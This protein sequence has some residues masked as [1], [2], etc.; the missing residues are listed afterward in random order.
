MIFICP[1]IEEEGGGDI[2][3]KYKIPGFQIFH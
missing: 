2:R 1:R 3:K